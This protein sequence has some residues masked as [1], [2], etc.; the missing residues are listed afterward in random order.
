MGQPASPEMIKC[1]RF[2]SED[3]NRMR[4]I[5]TVEGMYSDLINEAQRSG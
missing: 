4:P 2:L 5:A 3:E 1:L